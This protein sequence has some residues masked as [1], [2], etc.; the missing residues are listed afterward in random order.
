MQTTDLY[1]LI[2][3]CYLHSGD[4]SFKGV[5]SLHIDLCLRI[6]LFLSFILK[7]VLSSSRYQTD[8]QAGHIFRIIS[9]RWE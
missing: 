9:A 3:Y 7:F 5:I 8:V 6:S 4:E 2:R 1:V